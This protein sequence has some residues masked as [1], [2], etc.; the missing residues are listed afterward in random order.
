MRP[1]LRPGPKKTSPGVSII[2]FEEPSY[3]SL[4]KHW[5]L[6]ALQFQLAILKRHR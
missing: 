3:P 6:A 5:V 1:R 2:A 4:T